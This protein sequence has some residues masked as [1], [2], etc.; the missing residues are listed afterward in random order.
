MTDRDTQMLVDLAD[1]IRAACMRS[2]LTPELH[3][4]CDMV[5]ALEIWSESMRDNGPGALTELHADGLRRRIV[6]ALERSSP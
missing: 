3:Q 1:A 2:G 5:T 6:Q 4:V